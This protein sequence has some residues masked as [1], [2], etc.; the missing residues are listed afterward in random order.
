MNRRSIRRL[1]EQLERYH[2]GEF[3]DEAELDAEIERE[4]N[5]MHPEE[6]ERFLEEF[7]A[8]HGLKL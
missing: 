4:L 8:E 1:R 7:A 2:L 5:K 3:A 6:R